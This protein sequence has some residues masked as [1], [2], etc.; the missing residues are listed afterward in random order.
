MKK[1]V[2]VEV[3]KQKGEVIEGSKQ[4]SWG[5]FSDQELISN[6][7]DFANITQQDLNNNNNPS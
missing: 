7:R 5:K 2:S 1:E 6:S 3:V 4:I